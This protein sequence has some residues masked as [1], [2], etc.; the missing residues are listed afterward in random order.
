MDAHQQCTLRIMFVLLMTLSFSMI[1][2][3]P[4]NNG[5]KEICI[6]VKLKESFTVEG[7]KPIELDIFGCNGRCNS[8]YIPM[9]LKIVQYCRACLPKYAPKNHTFECWS[10]GKHHKKVISL[11]TKLAECKCTNVDC[12]RR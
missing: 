8:F 4:M 10:N 3:I 11:D 6:P 5:S 2:A 1:L 9:F 12:S 7:C